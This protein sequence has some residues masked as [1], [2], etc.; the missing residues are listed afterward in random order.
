MR[1]NGERTERSR[2]GGRWIVITTNRRT[3]M[4]K[5][6]AHQEEHGA[7]I[8][9]MFDEGGDEWGPVQTD[10]MPTPADRDDEESKGNDGQSDLRP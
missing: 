4:D 5:A 7:A 8:D 2:H 10:N 9:I 3:A 6:R 1:E